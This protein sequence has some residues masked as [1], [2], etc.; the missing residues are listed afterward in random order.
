MTFD[1]NTWTFTL[2]PNN[3]TQPF[4]DTT[5]SGVYKLW[6]LSRMPGASDRLKQDAKI[7]SEWL[8]QDIGPLTPTSCDK[9]KTGILG[10]ACNWPAATPSLQR[11]FDL[12]QLKQSSYPKPPNAIR[13][14]FDRW[15]SGGNE[16][17]VALI[18]EKR[19]YDDSAEMIVEQNASVRNLLR[20]YNGDFPYSGDLPKKSINERLLARFYQ[21]SDFTKLFLVV[22]AAWIVWVW[23]RT[24]THFRLVGSYFGQWKSD[25][26][27]PNL[28]LV[29]V[30]LLVGR[31]VY[32]LYVRRYR[33]TEERR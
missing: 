8:G 27:L 18:A 14:A 28:L 32:K 20:I 3:P 19:K 30:L 11:C 9:L 29:P 16:K 2:E 22:T 25:M 4:I 12:L 33:K 21:L 23:I 13:D 26:V 6:D 5:I 10:Y 15:F 31:Y 7:I 24:V 17:L 1:P